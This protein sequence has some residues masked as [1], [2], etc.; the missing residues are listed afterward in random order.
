MHR[1]DRHPGPRGWRRSSPGLGALTVALLL[2]AARL[3]DPAAASGQVSEKPVATAPSGA[4]ALLGD[5]RG[6]S[7]QVAPEGRSH[8]WEMG[9][10]HTLLH[11]S[12]R[13][14]L[15]TAP[16]TGSD[17]KSLDGEQALLHR[18]KRPTK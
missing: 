6:L 12:P 3:A 5:P 14:G 13:S 10:T 4:Q 1:D 7:V 16:V 11:R 8:A 2:G 18:S 15:A 9:G 17:R